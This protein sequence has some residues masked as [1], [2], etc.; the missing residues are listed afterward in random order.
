V[1]VVKVCPYSKRSLER[2]LSNYRKYGENGLVSKST[3]P[4]TNPVTIAAIRV[5][6]RISFKSDMVE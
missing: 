6:F 1:D 5:T 3:R 2:W 4:K